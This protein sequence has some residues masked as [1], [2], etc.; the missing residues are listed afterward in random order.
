VILVETNDPR[1]REPV[2]VGADALE[3]EVGAAASIGP[4]AEPRARSPAIARRS[5]SASARKISS[6]VSDMSVVSH[7]MLACS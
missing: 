1:R 2:E 4:L 3:R 7:S 6:G 5:G